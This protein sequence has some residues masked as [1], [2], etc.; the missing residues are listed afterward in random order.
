[1]TLELLLPKYCFCCDKRLVGTNK[2]ICFNCL[3][4]LQAPEPSK[5]LDFISN[6]SCFSSIETVISLFRYNKGG[7]VQSMLFKLKYH[8]YRSVAEELGVVLADKIKSEITIDIDVVTSIPLHST[9]LFDRGYNQSEL[10]ARAVATRLDLDYGELLIKRGD[11]KSQTE[12]GRFD[13]FSNLNDQFELSLHSNVDRKTVLVVDDVITT[14]ATLLSAVET[15]RDGGA[16]KFILS[17]IGIALQ[18]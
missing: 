7:D 4:D 6:L 3:F 10:I 1:M 16:S 15:L 2:T 9:K 5:V 18:N 12:K 17:S 11:T 13:R 8:G 14:G